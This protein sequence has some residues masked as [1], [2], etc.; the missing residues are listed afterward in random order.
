M[1]CKRITTSSLGQLTID[2]FYFH[3]QFLWRDS[4]KAALGPCTQ[5]AGLNEDL[6]TQDSVV[7]FSVYPQSPANHSNAPYSEG[8]IASGTCLGHESDARG[9][10]LVSSYRE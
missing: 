8:T 7:Q 6:M 2:Q 5:L 4:L 3:S 1:F 9:P 10:K